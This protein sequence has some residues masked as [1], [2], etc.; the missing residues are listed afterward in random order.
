MNYIF[1][2]QTN[3]GKISIMENGTAITNLYF[4]EELYLL[5]SNYDQL[6][7]SIKTEIIYLKQRMM[8]VLLYLGNTKE[9][10]VLHILY[11][12]HFAV[13]LQQIIYILWQRS[14]KI[15]QKEVKTILNGIMNWS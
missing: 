2:Y 10:A 4:L 9:K 12:T 15:L 6:I 5:S 14:L 1:S 7:S 13:T 8:E 11:F 3:I